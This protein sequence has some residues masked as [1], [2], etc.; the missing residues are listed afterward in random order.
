MILP[1]KLGKASYDIEI[2]RGA[3]NLA[4]ERI[5]KKGRKILVVTDSGVPKE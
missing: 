1:V 4:A 3:I 2:S 5:V